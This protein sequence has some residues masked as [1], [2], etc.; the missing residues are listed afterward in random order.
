MLCLLL[1]EAGTIH[2]LAISGCTDLRIG[3]SEAKFDVEVD[4]DVKNFLAPPKS[5]ENQDKPKKNCKKKSN[6]KFSASIIFRFGIV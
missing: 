2:F 4:F 6:K 5:A 3:V 1:A